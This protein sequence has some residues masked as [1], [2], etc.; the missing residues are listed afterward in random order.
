VTLEMISLPNAPERDD[1]G[2][3]VAP[4]GCPMG[5]MR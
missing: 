5:A 4:S 2:N 3:V 1:G